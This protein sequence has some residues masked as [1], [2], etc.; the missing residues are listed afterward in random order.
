MVEMKGLYT[1]IKVLLRYGRDK[2]LVYHYTIQV[3]QGYD[4]DVKEL[5]Y[6]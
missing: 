3:L 1:T 4:R 5:V 6:E 2:G